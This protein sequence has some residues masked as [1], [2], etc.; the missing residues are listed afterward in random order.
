MNQELEQKGIEGNTGC[1]QCGNQNLLTSIHI[2]PWGTTGIQFGSLL[3]V[4]FPPLLQSCFCQIVL[5]SP[6]GKKGGFPS[7][8]D[9]ILIFFFSYFWTFSGFFPF[10]FSNPK[11]KKKGENKK[12][13]KPKKKEKTKK[14]QHFPIRE[15]HIRLHF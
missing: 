7:K 10:F 13:E 4:L 6:C 9:N 15:K 2:L 5:F 3:L 11:K 14:K 12:K 8:R 1:R